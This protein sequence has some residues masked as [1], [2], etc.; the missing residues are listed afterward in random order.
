LQLTFREPPRALN[1]ADGLG[2][3]AEAA[4]AFAPKVGA[5]ERQRG[6]EREG[7]RE[8]WERER[9]RERERESE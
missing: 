2:Y 8:R 1:P 9:G 4:A 7:E 3:V 5:R 6:R